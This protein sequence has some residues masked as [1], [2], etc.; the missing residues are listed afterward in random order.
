MEISYHAITVGIQIANMIGIQ[1]VNRCLVV[2]LVQIS[3]VCIFFV[4]GEIWGS[5]NSAFSTLLKVRY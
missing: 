1:M 4:K 3:G 2:K 5:M